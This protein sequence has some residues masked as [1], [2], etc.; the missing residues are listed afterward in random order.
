[1]RI[2]RGEDTSSIADIHS[3]ALLF[4]SA[5]SNNVYFDINRAVKEGA[6]SATA[7]DKY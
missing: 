2:F 4:S 6:R 7:D 1:M 3:L 5:N